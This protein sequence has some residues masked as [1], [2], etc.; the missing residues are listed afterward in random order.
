MAALVMKHALSRWSSTRNDKTLSAQF[1][2]GDHH[3]CILH[4][5]RPLILKGK[6]YNSI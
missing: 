4:I 2:L 5:S 3:V 1:S 6:S